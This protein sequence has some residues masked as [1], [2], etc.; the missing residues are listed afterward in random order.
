MSLLRT[1]MA[2]FIAGFNAAE[3]AKNNGRNKRVYRFQHNQEQQYRKPVSR[4]RL[5]DNSKKENSFVE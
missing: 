4:V 2:G 3:R 1:I 5:A